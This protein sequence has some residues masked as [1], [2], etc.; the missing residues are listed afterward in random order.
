MPCHFPAQNPSMAPHQKQDKL[1]VPWPDTYDLQVVGSLSTLFPHFPS[2]AVRT[3]DLLPES[4]KTQW[5]SRGSF[6][7]AEPLTRHYRESD[8]VRE[9]TRSNYRM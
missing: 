6:G 5:I 4:L 1:Q 8:T 3:P 9:P 2:L 7:G